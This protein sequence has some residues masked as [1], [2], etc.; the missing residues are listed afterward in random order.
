MNIRYDQIPALDELPGKL[1]HIFGK[2][3]QWLPIYI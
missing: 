3:I 1:N 2:N